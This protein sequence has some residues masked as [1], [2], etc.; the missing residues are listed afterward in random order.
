MSQ[1]NKSG[2][3][4]PSPSSSDTSTSATTDT[5]VN[6]ANL[7]FQASINEQL[8]AFKKQMMETLNQ[9]VS[10]YEQPTSQGINQTREQ[11]A[12]DVQL[13][14]SAGRKLESHVQDVEHETRLTAAFNEGTERVLN[15]TKNGTYKSKYIAQHNITPNYHPAS[16]TTHPSKQVVNAGSSIDIKPVV[17]DSRY[18]SEAAHL[19]TQGDIV[20]KVTQDFTNSDDH[21]HRYASTSTTMSS[22]KQLSQPTPVP[23]EPMDTSFTVFTATAPTIRT[24]HF[25]SQ[26][27]PSTTARIQ[28]SAAFC[29]LPEPEVQN[30][31]GDAA[32][33]TINNPI[34]IPSQDTALNK[35]IDPSTDCI[36]LNQVV[37]V[38]H[39]YANGELF[40]SVL[41]SDNVFVSTQGGHNPEKYDVQ[42]VFKYES[43]EPDP[44]LLVV[45]FIQNLDK[46]VGY[47]LFDNPQEYLN[48]G[49]WRPP[50]PNF[51]A[52][53]PRP[54]AIWSTRSM[55]SAI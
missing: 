11:G 1:T 29:D 8:Q 9:F 14:N 48:T 38:G 19:V 15:T 10:R 51:R 52:G 47:Y 54:S 12:R 27:D 21:G 4:S 32:M 3:K 42:N 25:S 5:S 46:P 16:G 24:A 22:R 20:N 37:T 49:P 36:D 17:Q 53:H 40:S 28:P 45:D 7:A 13:F 35:S 33:V 50:P 18:Q 31:P 44:D 23:G 43:F 6:A 39:D 2:Q 55:V 26:V 34:P 30:M 41:Q